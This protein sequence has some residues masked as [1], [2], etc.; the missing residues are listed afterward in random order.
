MAA[1]TCRSGH[2]RGDGDKP[3]GAEGCWEWGQEGEKAAAGL[4][5]KEIH[6]AEGG[7]SAEPEGCER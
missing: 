2:L 4:R 6:S 1:L 7:V 3:E 5:S